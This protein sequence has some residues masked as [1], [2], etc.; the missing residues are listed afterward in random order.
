MKIAPAFTTRNGELRNVHREFPRRSICRTTVGKADVLREDVTGKIEAALRSGLPATI[1][2]RQNHTGP[3]MLIFRL[4]RSGASRGFDIVMGL[5]VFYVA[6]RNVK[7]GK[8]MLCKKETRVKCLCTAQ[9]SSLVL[10][11]V[12]LV[13]FDDF[14]V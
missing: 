14:T 5:N 10:L 12:F 4:Q 7:F 3:W 2:R 1:L 8:K 6:K 11:L 9:T 13:D